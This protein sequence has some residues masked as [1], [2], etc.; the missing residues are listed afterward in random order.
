MLDFKNDGKVIRIVLEDGRKCAVSTEYIQKNMDILGEDMEDAIMDWL[1]DE[2]Y[3]INEEQEELCIAA[4]ENKVLIGAKNENKTTEKKKRT[5]KENPTK[6]MIIAEVSKSIA[7]LE[8]VSDLIIEN[9]GK[10]ITFNLN[11]ESFKI[12]LTQR[13]KKNGV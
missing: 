11:G 6:E 9:K 10:I 5:V 7:A 2:G 1:E 13:R 12:D 3:L 8:G 4:K